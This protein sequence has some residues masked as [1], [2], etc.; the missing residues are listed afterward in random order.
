M[1]NQKNKIAMSNM[2]QILAH[3]VK[4]PLSGIRGAAQI[5][6]KMLKVMKLL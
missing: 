1:K 6:E 5:L 4:N 3:E 2:S